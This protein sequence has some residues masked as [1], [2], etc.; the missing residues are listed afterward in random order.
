MRGRLLIAGLGIFTSFAPL[1]AQFPPSR[2][3]APYTPASPPIQIRRLPEPLRPQA[4]ILPPGSPLPPAAPQPAASSPTTQGSPDGAVMPASRVETPLPQP[5]AKFAIDSGAVTVKKIGGSWQ[6]WAGPLPLKNLGNDETGAKDIVR[7]MHEQRPTEWV[8]IG[9]PRPIVEYGLTN[10]RP[11]ITAGFP[12]AVAPIDLRTVRVEPVKGVWCLKD[13]GNIHFNFGLNKGDA[14][15]AL[16]VIRKYGFNRIGQVGS[17]ANAP[18]LTYFFVALEADGAKP[19]PS[20]ALALAAQENG[21]ARTGIPVPGVGY[22]GEMVKID[23]RKIEVRRDGADWLV[24][25]GN[26]VL[27]RF[28]QDQNAARDAQRLIKDGQF[29][30]FCRAGPPGLTFFLVNGQSPNRVPLFVQGRRFD[31]KGLKA[32]QVGPRWAVTERGRHLFDV[33]SAEEGEAAIALLKHYQFD[34]LC[35]VGSS[36]RASLIFLA[37]GR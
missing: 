29:T 18:A 24:S 22:I 14:D 8:Q 1:F 31:L 35:Q 3:P 33:N 25:C 15:Q 30:E 28:G 23:A 5:E 27:A 32:S 11:A 7:V 34:Q 21:L 36:P 13:A 2:G 37:K 16:A 26:E 10:G 20:N 12:R 19:A 9:S 17:D 6:V 4:P